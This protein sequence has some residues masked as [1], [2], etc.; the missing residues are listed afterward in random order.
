VLVQP[1]LL[2]DAQVVKQR[3]DLGCA[4]MRLG[5]DWSAAGRQW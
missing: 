2:D 3:V 5:C 1:L 4:C